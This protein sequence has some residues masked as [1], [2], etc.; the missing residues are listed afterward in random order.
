M[1]KEAYGK[2]DAP[3]EISGDDAPFSTSSPEKRMR[4]DGIPRTGKD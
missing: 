3:A 1:D 4:K 2:E